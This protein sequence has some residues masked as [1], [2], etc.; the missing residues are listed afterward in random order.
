M[1]TTGKVPKLGFGAGAIAYVTLLGFTP[2]PAAPGSGGVDTTRALLGPA[3]DGAVATPGGA[4][5]GTPS[6]LVIG[7]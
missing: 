3:F 6:G 2:N 1:A 4:T 7:S 5:L